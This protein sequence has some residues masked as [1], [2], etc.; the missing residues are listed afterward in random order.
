MVAHTVT[1]CDRLC[2]LFQWVLLQMLS[3]MLQPVRV[4]AAVNTGSVGAAAAAADASPPSSHSL[5]P[6]VLAPGQVEGLK[7][8]RGHHSRKNKRPP[9]LSTASAAADSSTGG[10]SNA[11]AAEAFNSHDRQVCC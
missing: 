8:Q 9:A 4:A 3:A 7:E 5:Q 6:R 2:Q 1:A 11:S 10:S